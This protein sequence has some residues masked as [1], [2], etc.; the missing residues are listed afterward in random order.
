MP[1][2]YNGKKIGWY[3]VRVYT[4]IPSAQS[5]R[6]LLIRGKEFQTHMILI[7]DCM[8]VGTVKDMVNRSKNTHL[9]LCLF[10]IA[11][12]WMNNTFNSEFKT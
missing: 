6:N 7:A 1:V 11:G 8:I 2:S 10:H 9:S 5:T 4:L 3:W 12:E